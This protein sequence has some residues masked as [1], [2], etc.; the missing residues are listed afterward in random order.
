MHQSARSALR[1]NS[2]CIALQCAQRLLPRLLHAFDGTAASAG[3]AAFFEPGA[4]FEPA[5][6]L[7]PTA[8]E[9]TAK[10][11]YKPGGNY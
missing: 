7:G 10:D 2:S 11:A 8:F 9:L 5:A 3:P 1:F 6:F 4:F